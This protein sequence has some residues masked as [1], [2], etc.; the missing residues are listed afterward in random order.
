M[1]V[2]ISQCARAICWLPAA[3]LIASCGIFDNDDCTTVGVP[4]VGVRVVDAVTLA[5]LSTGVVVQL[6]GPN[7]DTDQSTQP[8]TGSVPP[9]YYVGMS[10][11]PGVYRVVVRAAGYQEATRD[12]IRVA[13]GEC[14]RGR[15]ADISISLTRA[16]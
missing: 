2:T 15:P 1:A 16:N 4:S 12:N 10:S 11:K 7:G 9:T 13:E 14:G 3:L 6:F 5:P 8:L